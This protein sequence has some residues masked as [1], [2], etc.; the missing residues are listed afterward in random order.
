MSSEAIKFPVLDFS[1]QELKP[2]TPL[3]D[4]LKVQVRKAFEEYG[5]FE[6]SFNKIPLQLSKYVFDAIEEIFDLPVQT[7]MKNICKK[8]FYGYFGQNPVIPLFE[9]MGIDDANIPENVEKF[10]QNLWPE[11][12]PII[13]YKTASCFLSFLHPCNHGIMFEKTY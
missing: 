9:S 8:A 10:V 7:K 6:A 5:C 1:D 11:G 4:S 12:N 3:W 2:G 13:R